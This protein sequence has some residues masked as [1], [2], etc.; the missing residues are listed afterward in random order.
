MAGVQIGKPITLDDTRK[1]DRGPAVKVRAVLPEKEGRSSTGFYGLSVKTL[2]AHVNGD[3]FECYLG[4]FSDAKETHVV[5]EGKRVKSFQWM[6]FVDPADRKRWEAW[7]A[8]QAKAKA[9]A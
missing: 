8:E 5:I 7:K 1:T 9:K 4:D 6:E 2:K 3:E